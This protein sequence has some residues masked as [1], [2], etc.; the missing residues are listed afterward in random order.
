MAPTG[1]PP[2]SWLGLSIFTCLCCCWPIGIA[3]IVYSVRSN[4]QKGANNYERA[5]AASK[6][7]LN[8]NIAGI[9]IG[10]VFSVVFGVLI[11][12]GV[13]QYGHQ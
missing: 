3:A 12:T 13:V 9:V 8:L 4:D 11:G 2:N 10:V 5:R 7:A 6:T 1:P